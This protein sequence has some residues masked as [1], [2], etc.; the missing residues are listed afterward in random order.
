MQPTRREK[1]V[2]IGGAGLLGLL[3]VLQ[4]VVHPA[5]ERLSM[6]RRVV[7]D[8]RVILADLRGKSLEYKSVE[9]EV[10]R[11]RS[12]IGQQQESRKILSSMERIRQ[13]CGLSENMLSL[14]PTTT[15]IDT[16][17]Q[18]TLVEV[19]LDGVKLVQLVAF[20]TQ[21]D[22]LHLAGGIK[23]L[24]VQHADRSPGSLRAVVQLATVTQIDRVQKR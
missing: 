9:A 21:L 14:K 17:Y 23:A 16:R 20:L 2:I 12:M 19:R 4:L 5:L 13:T 22:S 11:L 6:L 8:K 3:L 24:E 18:E 7:S 15:T 1:T 10:N